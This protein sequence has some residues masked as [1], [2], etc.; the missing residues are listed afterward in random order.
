MNRAVASI[1]SSW[2]VPTSGIR[3]KA[4]AKVPTML[5]AVESA[6]KRP[7][8]FPRP[9][10]ERARSRTAIGVAVARITLGTPKRITA[11]T[12]GFQRGP[13]SQSTT[14]SSTRSSTAGMRSVKPAPSARTPSSSCGAG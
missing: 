14:A 11:A 2:F 7:A 9:A 1:P 6:N 3:K 10:S 4:V 13:G 8:V 12:S 5:P